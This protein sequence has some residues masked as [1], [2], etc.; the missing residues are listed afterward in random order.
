MTCAGLA[1]ASQALGINPSLLRLPSGNSTAAAAAAA[2]AAATNAAL[3]SLAAKHEKALSNLASLQLGHQGL[4]L[5]A[6]LLSNG[7]HRG[8]RGG[9]D[10][11]PCMTTDALPWLGAAGLDISGS[12]LLSAMLLVGAQKVHVLD[13]RSGS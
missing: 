1:R 6:S 11:L 12:L 3:Q 4:D 7:E 5:S 13:R 9:K 8:G 2:A 10:S